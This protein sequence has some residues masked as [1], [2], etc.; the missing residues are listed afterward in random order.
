M[1]LDPL[2][3]W[4]LE[5]VSD[6]KI[7]DVFDT[8]NHHIFDVTHPVFDSFVSGVDIMDELNSFFF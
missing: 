5:I 4:S 1:L 8:L 7:E 6:R 2:C 3:S